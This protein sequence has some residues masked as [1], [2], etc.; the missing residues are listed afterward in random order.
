MTRRKVTSL[1]VIWPLAIVLVAVVLLLI[2]WTALDPWKWEREFVTYLPPE[3][4]G[5]CQSDHFGAFFWPL[6]GI[7][8]ICTFLTMLI[9]WKTKNVSQDLSDTSTVFYLIVTQAQA[10]FVGLPILVVIGDD[11][12]N[13][14]Y[15]GRVLLISLFA[16]APLLIVLFPRIYKAVHHLRHPEQSKT[17]RANVRITGI[18]IAQ[19]PTG[20]NV[21]SF[22]ATQYTSNRLSNT[23]S[24][25]ES[26]SMSSTG[27]SS[28]Y[29]SQIRNSETQR[30]SEM[31][32][33]E[34]EDAKEKK[35]DNGAA[36]DDSAGVRSTSSDLE[37]GD[38]VDL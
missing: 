17:K 3:T 1:Q 22:G 11:S 34:D 12:V 18:D 28:G 36:D 31:I 38:R 15:L 27:A 37:L 32:Q 9:V 24:G 26:K 13:T 20:S 5:K 14:V 6:T 2:L 30:I 33:E 4:F 29:S 10:W 35:A 23:A 21:S 7:L 8:M 19:L 25:S 16:M